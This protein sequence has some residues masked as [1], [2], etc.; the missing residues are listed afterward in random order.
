MHSYIAIPT[1]ALLP[2][3]TPC[4]WGLSPGYLPVDANDRTPA[5]A[6]P[7]LH[8]HGYIGTSMAAGAVPSLGPTL[9]LSCVYRHAYAS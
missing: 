8:C 2:Q 9:H 4:E 6:L 1:D 5:W 3:G 7:R